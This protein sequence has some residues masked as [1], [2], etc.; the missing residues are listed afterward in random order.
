MAK[1]YATTEIR[2]EESAMVIMP[3]TMY[4]PSKTVAHRIRTPSDNGSTAW[5]QRRAFADHLP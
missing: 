4:S 5:P 3:A 2:V 1:H